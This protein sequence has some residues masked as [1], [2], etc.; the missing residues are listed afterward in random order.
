MQRVARLLELIGK[1]AAQAIRRFAKIVAEAIT[2]LGQ[3]AVQI[4]EH[5]AVFLFQVFFQ[6]RWQR[7]KL[8]AQRGHAP[9]EPARDQEQHN[10]E[11]DE[12][13]QHGPKYS[14]RRSV[15]PPR[16]WV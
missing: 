8:A 2:Q 15:Y 16:K 7:L 12:E 9:G 1:G 10:G 13:F 5:L 6:T 3:A 4:L 14:P 11:N